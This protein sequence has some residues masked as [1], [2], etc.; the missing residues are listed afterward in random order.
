MKK[1]FIAVVV[2]LCAIAHAHAQSSLNYPPRGATSLALP[3]ALASDTHVL[4]KTGGLTVGNS[5][6]TYDGSGILSVGSRVRIGDPVTAAFR[7]VIRQ[8]TEGS[9][10]GIGLYNSAN[11]ANH[12]RIYVDSDGVIKFSAGT[13]PRITFDASS[14]VGVLTSSP[15][16]TLHVGGTGVVLLQ[17]QGSAPQTCNSTAKGAMA[18]TST[19]TELC[20]CNGTSWLQADS[21]S[22]CSW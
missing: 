19:T 4:Y 5:G 3:M 7:L 6:L 18:M 20:F 14:R 21:G 17:P 9:S 8:S 16:A 13:S 1:Y 2:L 10:N 12:L 22:A 15:S 11:G